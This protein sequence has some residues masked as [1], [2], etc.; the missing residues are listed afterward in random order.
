MNK[1]LQKVAKLFLGLSMAAGVGVAISSSGRK[2]AKSAFATEETGDHSLIITRDS[3]TSGNGYSWCSWSQKTTA[4]TPDTITGEAYIYYTTTSSMQ[5]NSSKSGYHIF[6]SV[7]LP[8]RINSITASKASGTT[9]TW[10]AKVAT[11]AYTRSSNTITD[12]TGSTVLVNAGTS[13]DGDDVSI[14][15]IAANAGDYSYFCLYVSGG[16]SYISDFTINYT[17]SSASTPYSTTVNVDHGAKS[18][19]NTST[20]F[21]STTSSGDV[22]LT[23]SSGYRAPTTN[24]QSAFSVSGGH[25]QIGTITTVSNGD[26]KIPLTGVDA[27][28]T[29]TGAFE[30]IPTYT[31]TYNA[32]GGTG[33]VPASTTGSGAI[34]LPSSA[35][36]TNS[37]FKLDG[38]GDV[39]HKDQAVAQYALGAS[40]TLSADITLYAHW[41]TAYVV[42]FDANGGT[43]SMSAINDV[44]GSY[45]LPANGFTPPS[46]KTF[47]GWKANNS[48][49]IIAVGGS[50]N[51]NAN[52]KFYAQWAT[53]YTDVIT[54]SD[55]AATGTGYTSF[56][57]VAKNSDARYL[58]K[59]AKDSSGNIQCNSTSGNG[60]ATSVSGGK[61]KTISVSWG[62]VPSGKGYK[63]YGNNTSYASVG[64]SGTQIGTLNGDTTT[65]NV[66]K[67]YEYVSLQGYG[68]ASYAASLTFVWEAPEKAPEIS[69]V[70]ITTGPSSSEVKDGGSTWSMAATTT[71]KYDDQHTLSTNVTWSVSPTGA[72]TFSKSE[73]ESGET[74][75]VT[76]TNANYNSVVITA[77]SVEEDFDTVHGD[78]NTFSIV[79]TFPIDSVSL[80]ATTSGGPDYDAEGESSFTV[81]FTTAITYSDDTGSNKVNISVTPS[82]GVTGQGDD[83]TAGNFDLVFTK[84][85]TYTVTSTAAENT[86]KSASVQISIGNI[87][88]DGFEKVTSTQSI[89]NGSKVIIGSTAKGTVMGTE[90]ANALI[91]GVSYTVTDDFIPTGDTT[92]FGIFDMNLV[93]GYWELTTTISSVKSWLAIDADGNRADFDTSSSDA[94][95]WTVDFD[96]GDVV[97]VPKSY[98]SRVLRCNDGNSNYGCYAGSQS[99]IQLYVKV[100][101]S[102]YFSINTTSV[103]L[104]NRG[105][106][107]LQLTAHNKATATVTWSKSGDNVVNLSTLSGLST[108]ITAVDSGEGVATVTATF[109]N[110]NGT[111]E[112][113]AVRVEVIELDMYVNVGMT[114]FTKVT[115]TPDGGWA[116]TYLL[117]DESANAIFDG[118]ASPLGAGSEKSISAPGNTIEATHEMIKSSFNIKASTHGYTIRSNS[119]YFIG[120]PDGTTKTIST[121][122]G[123]AYEV[124]IGSDGTITALDS[125]GSA[126]SSTL[127]HIANDHLWRF[128]TTT[129]GNGIT[130]Y[131][132]DG[133]ARAISDTITAWYDNAKTNEYL[134]CNN[135]S[136]QSKIS[137]DNLK[138]GSYWTAL[139]STD[140]DTLKRMTAKAAED[141]GNYLE[142]F[143]SDYD[144]LIQHIFKNLE[145][146]FLGRFGSGGAMEGQLSPRVNLLNIKNT[147]TVAILVIISMVSVTTIGG[148][149]FLR[150]RREEN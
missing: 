29:I 3:F 150:K 132:A 83:M 49:D 148:Y 8:G 21:S 138:T 17:V 68:G 74:I 117:V 59:T 124:S 76:A 116:G 9:R 98:T 34:N 99:K 110:G 85:G 96:N 37:G 134:V 146:D 127:R 10:Y 48:G 111:F 129:S 40:Y 78:S 125:E 65:I 35:S 44:L 46:S 38:W 89:R 101:N 94:T 136:T 24:L 67:D 137:W 5:F 104:G 53:R 90:K 72:V 56:S 12:G 91:K 66:T 118:S 55:L 100:D 142:D 11:T 61:I 126:T 4:T 82:G 33:S 122:L 45:T 73:S 107:L 144:Y 92:S 18:T 135:D 47:A 19:S 75:S 23:P 113:I 1:L 32:N 25:A 95:K 120:N 108:T 81:S 31:I 145:Y 112:A 88:V 79:K 106:Q 60:I 119:N 130:L 51:V 42:S 27:N 52:V 36:L 41:S 15:T 123:E 30:L 131:K 105:T 2:D 39:S 20:S 121:S 115:S 141:E 28:I 133:E 97:L 43:G 70:A 140:K 6:N 147:N 69:S 58:G 63:V 93:N 77:T 103:Y 62:T 14:G 22:Y 149:F 114:T 13:V 71:A 109:T 54:A 80:S 143:I 84:N 64:S 50:Y 26:V 102:P 7:A 139:S 128:Y 87:P 57:N 86:N 16:A